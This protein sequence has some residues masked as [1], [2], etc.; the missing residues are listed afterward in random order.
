MI[1]T[2][3]LAELAV[4]ALR[5]VRHPQSGLAAALVVAAQALEADVVAAFLLPCSSEPELLAAG[6]PGAAALGPP[7]RLAPPAQAFA[8]ALAAGTGSRPPRPW[9]SH[10]HLCHST[11]LLAGGERIVIAAAGPAPMARSD[12]DRSAAAAPLLAQLVVHERLIAR[13]REQLHQRGQERS[14]LAAALQ[15]QIRAPLAAVLGAASTLRAHG[16]HLSDAE[17]QALLQSIELRARQLTELIAG[18]L[19]RQATGPDAPLDVKV[20]GL[21]ALA[22]RVAAAAELLHGGRVVVESS[23]INLTTDP[24]RV[25]RALL[26]LLGH[27][28][29]RSPS[30]SA[31]HLIVEP[32]CKGAALTVADNGAEIAADL[33]PAL[34][35]AAPAHHDDAVGLASVRLIAEQLSGR[36]EHLRHSGWTRITLILPDLG[37]P[38]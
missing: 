21:E 2:P 11:T 17:R 30:G 8:A 23:E 16:G 24:E 33:L 9:D 29:A 1:A 20:A 13:L 28:L 35:G 26:E 15:D 37:A 34:F 19:S 6:G 12:L 38:R 14:L 36:I 31:V 22:R 18:A 25:A 32:T 4:R 10:P 27:A 3:G 5:S 7:G